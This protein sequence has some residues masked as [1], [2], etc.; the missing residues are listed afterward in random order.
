MIAEHRALIDDESLGSAIDSLLERF[1]SEVTPLLP[2]LRRSAVHNDL[3]DHN[4]L[5]GGGD[6]I[7]SRRQRVTGIVDFGDMVY[8]YTVADLAIAAAYVCLDSDD[9]LAALAS[10]ARGYHALFPLTGDEISALFGLIVLRLCT[11][12]CVA[13]HPEQPESGQRVSRHQ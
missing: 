13:A 11:S 10:L 3:N 9:P 6:D 8:G 12:A 1:D 4:V 7:Y 2:A 5:V